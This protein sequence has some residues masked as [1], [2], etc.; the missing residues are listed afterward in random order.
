MKKTLLAVLLTVVGI[1]TIMGNEKQNVLGSEK[2]QVKGLISVVSRE[3]GSGTR[4]A[5]VELF[6]IEEKDEHGNRTDYTTVEAVIGNSTEIIVAN[7][8]GDPN[9]IG[10][11]SM[12]A[13]N[14]RTKPVKING[15]EPTGENV[16]NGNYEIARPFTV[17]TGENPSEITEDFLKFI[18]STEGQEIVE[19]KG[20]IPFQEN[21]QSYTSIGN[22]PKGK[23][24]IA[25]SSSVSP[26]MELLIEGYQKV[27]ENAVIELQTND[28]TTGIQSVIDGMADMG[29]V[30]RDLKESESF[31]NDTIIALDGIVVIVNPKNQKD[32]FT[33]E[34]VRDIFTGKIELWQDVC[35]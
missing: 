23:I 15:I 25:G 28:S 34:Q 24:V 14:D 7:V 16:K 26:V 31:L 20:Y 22:S 1:S 2:N 17:V 8:A 32:D 6:G 30:S 21:G 5:F 18:L 29:M 27:N 3:D 11:I 12:G 9:A 35:P 10:Y 4:G 33:V 19:G 13:M